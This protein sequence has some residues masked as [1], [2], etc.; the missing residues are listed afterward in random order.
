MTANINLTGG[1]YD[2]GDTE[3]RGYS[4]TGTDQSKCRV[5][6][7]GYFNYAANPHVS[8]LNIRFGAELPY[9]YVFYNE[10]T[11]DP[12][13]IMRAKVVDVRASIQVRDGIKL[14]FSI[15]NMLDFYLPG[16][17][18]VHDPNMDEFLGQ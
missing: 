9:F 17:S 10:L 16:Q 7:N 18:V 13:K 11:S 2:A 12:L 5:D 6:L 14:D 1:T 8:P 4:N 15:E 3:S